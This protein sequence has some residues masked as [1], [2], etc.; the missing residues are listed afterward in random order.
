[1]THLMT[2]EGFRMDRIDSLEWRIGAPDGRVSAIQGLEAWK[3]W[4][5]LSHQQ[6]H[7]PH[8]GKS[9]YEFQTFQEYARYLNSLPSSSEAIR[10]FRANCHGTRQYLEHDD[11][12]RID[13]KGDP[14]LPVKDGW[15]EYWIERSYESARNRFEIPFT[16]GFAHHLQEDGTPAVYH[17]GRVLSNEGLCFDKSGAGVDQIFALKTI[18]E[19]QTIYGDRLIFVQRFPRRETPWRPQGKMKIRPDEIQGTI[20]YNLL[21]RQERDYVSKLRE[22]II[23]ARR[24]ER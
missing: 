23:E 2:K 7:V 9:M 11:E 6:T 20:E 3:V 21:R 16:F 10:I 17:S 8:Q 22:K 5:L 13:M 24:A 18:E 12:D 14:I 1:M 4:S 19:L 15:G